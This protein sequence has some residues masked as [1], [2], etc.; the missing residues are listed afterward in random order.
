MSA[1]HLE[2]AAYHLSLPSS[3]VER[4]PGDPAGALAELRELAASSA[5]TSLRSVDL[6]MEL[7]P[8][9]IRIIEDG[10]VAAL[11]L[12]GVHPNIVRNFAG[13]FGIDYVDRYRK[14]GLRGD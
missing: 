7:D 4:H 1:L 8:D 5:I 14:A 13:A 6:R 11:Y 2:R 10:D 3:L 12:K 9:E